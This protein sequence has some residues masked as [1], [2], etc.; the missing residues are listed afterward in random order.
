MYKTQRRCNTPKEAEGKRMMWRWNAKFGGKLFRPVVEM[1]SI[2]MDSPSTS[3]SVRLPLIK[4]SWYEFNAVMPASTRRICSRS[5]DILYPKPYLG[6][7]L[8][9]C[10]MTT[11]TRIVAVMLMRYALFVSGR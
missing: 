3:S 9:L 4:S 10:S 11:L 6:L 8:A 7:N 5:I 2:S 1:P